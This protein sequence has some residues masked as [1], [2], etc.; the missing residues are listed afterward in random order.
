MCF[1]MM[2]A[3]QGQRTKLIGIELPCPR[4]FEGCLHF[5]HLQMYFLIVENRLERKLCK[6]KNMQWCVLRGAGVFSSPAMRTGQTPF[7]LWFGRGPPLPPPAT[8]SHAGEGVACFHYWE[9]RGNEEEGGSG[10]KTSW[11]KGRRERPAGAHSVARPF[12]SH[13]SGRWAR[14]RRTAH[15]VQVGLG[16]RSAN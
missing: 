10:A 12:W 1:L 3:F 15:G 7:S 5:F 16:R 14:R 8:K 4:K 9:R 2:K 13:R 11:P 6:G